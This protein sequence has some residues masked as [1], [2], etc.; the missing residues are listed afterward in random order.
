MNSTYYNVPLPPEK[1][2]LYS[3]TLI[4]CLLNY[5]VEGINQISRNSELFAVDPLQL[6]SKKKLINNTKFTHCVAFVQQNLHS[7]VAKIEREVGTGWS[8]VMGHLTLE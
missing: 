1:V 3:H 6:W 5:A 2:E 4:Y 7:K 8:E